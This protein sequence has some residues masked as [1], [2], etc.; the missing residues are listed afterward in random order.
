MIANRIDLS[1]DRLGAFVLAVALSGIVFTSA[2]AENEGTAEQQAACQ[3]NAMRLCS[4]EIPDVARITA[5][6][7][8][9]R[10]KLSAGCR[11][12]FVS[13]RQQR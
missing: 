12:M 2:N 6:M 9:N 4:S 1:L 13:A 8:A 11:A 10:R 5:C 3:S 7:K